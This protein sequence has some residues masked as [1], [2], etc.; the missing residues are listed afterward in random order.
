MTV[1]PSPPAA[2]FLAARFLTAACQIHHP[3]TYQ[4]ATNPDPIL[5]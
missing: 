5:W 3:A 4:M 2:A 1:T